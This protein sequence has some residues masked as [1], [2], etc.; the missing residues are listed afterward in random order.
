MALFRGDRP[1]VE[2]AESGDLLAVNYTGE[3]DPKSGAPVVRRTGG[4]TLQ[5]P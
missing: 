2:D 4:P 3:R 1:S 5:T